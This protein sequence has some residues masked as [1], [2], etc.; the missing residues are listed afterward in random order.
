[1][2][3]SELEADNQVSSDILP[4]SS[5]GR[6]RWSKYAVWIL[7]GLGI[8]IYMVIVP[9]VGMIIDSF[10][11]TPDVSVLTEMTLAESLRLHTVSGVVMLMFLAAGA[12]IGSFLNVVIYR[13]PRG[14]PLLWPPS[15]CASCGTRLKGKDNLPVIAW[16]TLGGKCRYCASS[17]SARYP[18]V[19]AIVAAAFVLFYYRELMSGGQNLPVRL[20]NFY[21][22]I[23][24]IL[25]YTK[26]DL[27]TIYLFH[28]LLLCVLLTW[29]M[30]NYDRFRAPRMVALGSCIFFVGLAAAFPHLNPTSTTWNGRIAGLPGGL[31]VSLIGSLLGLAL[32]SVLDFVFQ[33]SEAE[34]AL[35]QGNVEVLLDG[36]RTTGTPSASDLSE[37]EPLESKIADGMR[38]HVDASSAYT[39]PSQEPEA[40]SKESELEGSDPNPQPTKRDD[41]YG[42]KATK[43]SRFGDAAA[44]LTLVGAALGPEAVVVVSAASCSLSIVTWLV[45]AKWPLTVTL[46]ATT[47]AFLVFW[48]SIHN[49]LSAMLVRIF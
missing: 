20:P 47:T 22:G 11:P 42:T 32:G 19:E 1:M 43:P 17:I 49:L 31:A 13:L 46:F 25:L 16:L 7:A 36:E 48:G 18:I 12:S 41:R 10:T 35:D 40:T 30:I 24:W 5:P 15:A 44:S 23:V 6:P 14:R 9:T 28:M 4:P 39:P 27:V 45:K 33:R 3:D 37:S 26:W 29:G 2:S 38:E 34:S 21:N 8:L